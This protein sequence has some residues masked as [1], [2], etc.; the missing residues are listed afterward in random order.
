MNETREA[1]RK[2]LIR[3]WRTRNKEHIRL[4]DYMRKRAVQSREMARAAMAA[5]H[6][7]R[8]RT[9]AGLS[10]EMSPDRIAALRRASRGRPVDA[11]AA[12][13]LRSV[14]L[15]RGHDVTALGHDMLRA[16]DAA[17]PIEVAARRLGLRR[18]DLN[19]R[20]DDGR[21]PAFGN[22]DDMMVTL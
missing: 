8:E 7:K 22:D 20:A 12:E 18:S 13:Y 17:L 19:G 4:Y 2:R 5:A 6:E 9:V 10:A 3:E 15:M 16:V 14:G 11:S 21:Y 1:R